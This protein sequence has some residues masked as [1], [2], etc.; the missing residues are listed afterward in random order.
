[1]II[2]HQ[3]VLKAATLTHSDAEKVNSQ[4]LGFRGVKIANLVSP[5][6][7]LTKSTAQLPERQQVTTA[8]NAKGPPCASRS[9]APPPAHTALSA[10]AARLAAEAGG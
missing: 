10:L 2:N 3:R 1:M 4:K 5:G 9:P 7:T 6:K 8:S